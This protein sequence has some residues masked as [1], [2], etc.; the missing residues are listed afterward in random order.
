MKKNILAVLTAVALTFAQGN[1]VTSGDN[2]LSV[3]LDVDDFSDITPGIVV[4]WDHGVSFAKS[5]TFGAQIFTSFY[6]EG[7]TISPSFRSGFHP[8]AMPT[9]QGKVK[10]SSVFD[11]YVTMGLGTSIWLGEGGFDM[12][13]IDLRSAVG[14]NW[15]FS[16]KVGL[17]GEIGN[18]F[19]IGAT[20]KL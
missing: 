10:I 16:E 4:S 13:I 19:V 12:N 7:V 1:I 2:L 6:S 8:F 5:F 20:F 18:Y 15:M 17:W 14:C 3:G 9:L 11:P